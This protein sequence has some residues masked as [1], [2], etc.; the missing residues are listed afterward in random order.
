MPEPSRPPLQT[1]VADQMAVA[2]RSRK[3][4]L[5]PS[6]PLSPQQ[7]HFGPDHE[8]ALDSSN[9]NNNVVQQTKPRGRPTGTATKQARLMTAGPH[10]F[11]PSPMFS[12]ISFG[13]IPLPPQV[14]QMRSETQQFV[15]WSVVER[16]PSF[17]LSPQ[18]AGIDNPY[19]LERKE[20]EKKRLISVTVVALLIDQLSKF[21]AHIKA[22]L[23]AT[24]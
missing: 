2:Q 23:R 1:E 3:H 17:S 19:K 12:M 11:N 14:F 21:L 13:N 4:Y 24:G 10:V 9:N 7:N 6:P 22:K 20:A 8:A 5:T 16:S 15:M 18:S